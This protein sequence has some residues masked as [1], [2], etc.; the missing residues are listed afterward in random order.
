[1]QWGGGVQST[2]YQRLAATGRRSPLAQFDQRHTV[3]GQIQVKLNFPKLNV[4]TDGV[5]EQF[6]IHAFPELLQLLE[7]QDERDGPD[8]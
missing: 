8:V 1:M 4:A 3:A 7:A 5:H 2:G 6:E